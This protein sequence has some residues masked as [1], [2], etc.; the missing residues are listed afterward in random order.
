MKILTTTALFFLMAISPSWASW[1]DATDSIVGSRVTIQSQ[2]GSKNFVD[3]IPGKMASLQLLKKT[4][5]RWN[6]AAVA[7]GVMTVIKDGEVIHSKI[8]AKGDNDFKIFLE[9]GQYQIQTTIGAKAKCYFWKKRKWTSLVPDGG[10]YATYMQ[11]RDQKFAYY[12]VSPDTIPTLTLTGPTKAYVFFRA[13]MPKTS[14]KVSVDVAIKAAD[15]IVNHKIADLKVSDNAEA[16]ED[17]SVKISEAMVLH[18]N[19]PEGSHKY[20]IHVVKCSGFVKFYKTEKKKKK[21]SSNSTGS[22]GPID[23]KNGEDEEIGDVELLSENEAFSDEGPARRNLQLSANLGLEYDNNV[24][25]Y[26]DG[27]KSGFTTVSRSYRYPGVKSLSDF[28]IPM[29]GKVLINFG[30]I[31]TGAGVSVNAFTS[32]TRLSTLG[33]N[34][35]LAW[36]GP[37]RLRLGYRLTPYDPVRPTYIAPRTYSMMRYSQNKA[38]LSALFNRWTLKP[39]ANCAFGYFDYNAVFDNYDAYFY[40]GGLALINGERF[41][42][43]LGMDMGKVLAK[44]NTTQDW[45][46]LYESIDLDLHAP[47][48]TVVMSLK[49]SL[50]H[51]GYST[52]DSLDSH[53]QRRDL[54]GDGFV[55]VK[56]PWQRFAA[57]TK[58]GCLWRRVTSPFSGID[59]E[60]DYLSWVSGIE[61][62]LEYECLNGR[63]TTFGFLQTTV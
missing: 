16:S 18:I 6:I 31:T 29:D 36:M 2:D 42:F 47:I 37:L 27:Y 5:T 23:D 25:R 39:S 58:F 22:I 12:R 10:G 9:K 8:L 62:F 59:E 33:F 7:K 57:T 56:Y 41:G 1:Y 34:A 43:R 21:F 13:D 15:S 45:S 61:F 50:V 49:G 63:I 44:H 24:Y 35:S 20:S 32:N 46:N 48:R 40:E 26:S 60:K 30:K 55:S 38:T 52:Q 54:S 51:K 3:F 14:L 53:Y 4:S 28:V 11:A 19:V 17:S